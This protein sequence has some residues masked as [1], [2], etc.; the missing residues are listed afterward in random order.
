MTMQRTFTGLA[1]A[2]LLQAASVA[3]AAGPAPAT[4]LLKPAQA[5]ERMNAQQAREAQA[6]TLGVQ[7]VLWG[8]QWV[9]ATR[10]IYGMAGALPPGAAPSP[11]DR[12]PHLT[13]VWSHARARYTHENRLVE[14]PNTETLYSFAVVDL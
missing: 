8:M 6:Y 1:V 5:F 14:T 13:N 12:Y 7:T 4:M 11:A 2:V 9:K 3:H 10:A